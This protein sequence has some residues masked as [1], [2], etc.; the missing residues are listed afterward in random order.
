[1]TMTIQYIIV[2][3]IIASAT[4]NAVFRLIRS[5]RRPAGKCDGCS[6]KCNLKAVQELKGRKS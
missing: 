4:G 1:M 2:G 5:G 3:L 6:A